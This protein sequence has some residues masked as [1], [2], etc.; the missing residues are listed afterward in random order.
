[1]AGLV[2]N[3]STNST[4]KAPGLVKTVLT[5]NINVVNKERMSDN[6]CWMREIK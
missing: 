6:V 2:C 5:K 4:P 3:L 1:M